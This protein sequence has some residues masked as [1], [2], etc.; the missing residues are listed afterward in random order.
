[1]IPGNAG[2]GGASETGGG[3]LSMKV[4]RRVT[5][6]DND[7]LLAGILGKVGK[8]TEADRGV[9]LAQGPRVM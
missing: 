7:S 4:V 5:I 2:R 6:M 1:M 9:Q 3:R 8:G